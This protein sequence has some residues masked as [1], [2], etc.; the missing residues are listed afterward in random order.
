MKKL[1][2]LAAVIF[3]IAST[4]KAQFNL[5]DEM[6]K[7]STLLFSEGQKLVYGVDF[8]GNEYDFIVTITSLDKGISF[9]YEMTNASNTKGSVFISAEAMDDGLAQNNM[10]SGGEMMLLNKTTVW[11]SQKVFTDL[12]ED[13]AVGILPDGV[14]QV[15]L[16]Q[17]SIGHDYKAYDGVDKEEMNDLSYVYAESDDQKYKYWIHLNKYYP[18]ILKMD[19]G[20]SIWL[21]EMRK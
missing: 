13:G 9:D 11:V 10:F 12:E 2:L 7:G 14:N 16:R 18:L 4:S 15:K 3:G 8:Y 5:D 1:L 19:I 21:K 6:M 20:W 17:K